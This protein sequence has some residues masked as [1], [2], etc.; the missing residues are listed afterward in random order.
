MK[1]HTKDE[2]IA[3]MK[4][5][6]RKKQ[7]LQKDINSLLLSFSKDTGTVIRTITCEPLTHLS[8]THMDIHMKEILDYNVKV[9][10]KL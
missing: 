10:I 2:C 1:E 6:Y 9:D 3:T 7:Q 8:M 5:L 4:F